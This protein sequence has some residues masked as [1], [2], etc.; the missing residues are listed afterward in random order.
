[1]LRHKATCNWCVIE[2]REG[3]GERGQ[4]HDAEGKAVLIKQDGISEA[5]KPHG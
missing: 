3:G 1:M 4:L 5:F 2:R